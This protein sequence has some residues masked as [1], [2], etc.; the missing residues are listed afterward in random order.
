MLAAPG[1]DEGRVRRVGEQRQPVGAQRDRRTRALAERRRARRGR[2]HLCPG[3]RR[4]RRLDQAALGRRQVGAGVGEVEAVVGAV[5]RVDVPGRPV[6]AHRGVH[7]GRG[8]VEPDRGRALDGGAGPGPQLGMGGGQLRLHHRRRCH[9]ERDQATGRVR[10]LDLPAGELLEQRGAVQVVRRVGARADRARRA[11]VG[12]GRG[13]RP[14]RVGPGRWARRLRAPGRA[15]RTGSRS[16]A[17]TSC[18]A[19]RA[20]RWVPDTGGSLREA[21][22]SHGGSQH[23]ARGRAGRAWQNAKARCRRSSLAFAR[24]CI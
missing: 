13:A 2:S 6:A 5:G 19:V 20:G 21:R 12:A 16:T 3:A 17:H 22:G 24:R 1:A 7:A 23:C 18:V 8:R 9:P 15:G 4:Q 10:D 14:D 11:R